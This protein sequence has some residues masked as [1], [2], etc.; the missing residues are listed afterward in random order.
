MMQRDFYKK[1]DVF[2]EW[3]FNIFIILLENEYEK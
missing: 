3:S 1:K 2:L